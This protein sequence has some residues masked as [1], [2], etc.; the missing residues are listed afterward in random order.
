MYQ[1]ELTF[2]ELLIKKY[3]IHD[4]DILLIGRGPKNGII[5]ND[6]SVSRL[7]AGIALERNV[8]RVWDS[9]SR[10]GTLVNGQE[11]ESAQLKND[12]VISIGR[13]LKIRVSITASKDISSPRGL[14]FIGKEA[15]DFMSQL[16]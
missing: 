12:D 3:T 15:E 2:R 6:P 9:E 1:L 4:G 11:V 14:E 16:E 5:V 7:H 10:N 8:L 13:K